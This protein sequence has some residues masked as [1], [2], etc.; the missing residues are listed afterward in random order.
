MEK[1]RLQNRH[2]KYPSRENFL[3]YKNIKT[4]A[5]IN[6]NSIYK[7]KEIKEIYKRY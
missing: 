1:S 5:I 6:Y 3:A 2:L 7:I 4:N